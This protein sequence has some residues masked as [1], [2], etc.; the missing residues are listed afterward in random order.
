[1]EW[2]TRL[3]RKTSRNCVSHPQRPQLSHL[4]ARVFHYYQPVLH[5]FTKH[6]F[7]QTVDATNP[8]PVD[9]VF[10][11]PVIYDGF[12]TS[13]YGGFLAKISKNHQ[14]YHH[15]RMNFT[16]W[17]TRVGWLAITDTV[18]T[19]NLQKNLHQVS[20]WTLPL[21]PFLQRS[22]SLT[23]HRDGRPRSLSHPKPVRAGG[24]TYAKPARENVSLWWLFFCV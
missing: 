8:A 13:H 1:M 21:H 18:T 2:S 12:H 11:Q 16:K 6:V 24:G 10:K 19:R 17:V 3:H 9:M 20:C 14:Q 4:M 7:S 15:L 22:R 23:L 5:H